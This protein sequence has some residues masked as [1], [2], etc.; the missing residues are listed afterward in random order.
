[1]HTKLD[2]TSPL[3][4]HAQVEGLLRDLISKKEYQDGKLLPNEVDLAKL[5]GISR[6]Q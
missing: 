4:L 3:P 1:M 6:I 2:H 5:L